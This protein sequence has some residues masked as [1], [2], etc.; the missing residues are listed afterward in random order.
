MVGMFSLLGVLFGMPL[1]EI[2][3]PLKLS[4]LLGDSLLRHE[5]DIGRFLQ[6]VE[7]SERLDE[8]RARGLLAQIGLTSDEWNRLT[9]K[10]HQ[11]MLGAIH[12]QQDARHA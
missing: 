4:A 10:A 2:V 9:L 3:K 7:S 6:C 1:A 11:W 8:P 12:E 5:G